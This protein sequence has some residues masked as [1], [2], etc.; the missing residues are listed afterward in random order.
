DGQLPTRVDANELEPDDAGRRPLVVRVEEDAREEDRVGPVVA[1]IEDEQPGIDV[2]GADG[3]DAGAEAGLGERAGPA[4][5]EPLLQPR[6]GRRRRGGKDRARDES[7]REHAGSGGV[8]P[9]LPEAADY[10][11][12]GELG[13][14]SLVARGWGHGGRR[15]DD[16]G[17]HAPGLTCS[18]TRP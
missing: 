7:L 14:G 8:G 18:S 6:P 2:V 1:R 17:I 12:R 9:R 15:A 13:K 4:D 5:L 3:A 10:T 16:L 11:V